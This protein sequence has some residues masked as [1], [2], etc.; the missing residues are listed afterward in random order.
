MKVITE[1][2]LRQMSVT[3]SMPNATSVINTILSECQELDQLTSSNDP[4]L[5]LAA[6]AYAGNYDGD[7][8]ELIKTD[9]L[10]AFYHGS[11]YQLKKDRNQL[12]VTRLRP[13]SEHNNDC[14]GILAAFHGSE[15]LHVVYWFHGLFITDQDKLYEPEDFKGWIHLPKYEPEQS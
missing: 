14:D 10:N 7:E 6:E 9:V 5:I 4:D 13:M 1:E 11:A 15:K 3:S 12:T 8:R 2:Q